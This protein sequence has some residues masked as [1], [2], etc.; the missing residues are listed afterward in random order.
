MHFWHKSEPPQT[1]PAQE[2]FTRLATALQELA[3]DAMKREAA[4]S[5]SQ[6]HREAAASTDHLEHESHPPPWAE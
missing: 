4:R 6:P 1:D 2:I 5:A 3:E